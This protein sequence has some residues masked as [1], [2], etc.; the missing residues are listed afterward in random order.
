M[1][2]HASKLDTAFIAQ[3]RKRLETLL[4]QMSTTTQAERA[5][6]ANSQAEVMGQAREAEDDAQRL[7][8]LEVE[9][10]LVGRNLDRAAQIR[11]ALEKIDQGTY[12]QSDQSGAAIPRDRLEAEPEAILT[13][14]EQAARE[15]TGPARVAVTSVPEK[16]GTDSSRFAA[17]SMR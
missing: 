17:G 4:A 3:Q 6:E 13:I 5:D 7:D 10:T 12:G 2:T 1:T 11:R 9:G 14:Q 8:Q 16:P 15:K